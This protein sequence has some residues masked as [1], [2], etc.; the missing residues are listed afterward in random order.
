MV[1]SS[2]GNRQK[3]LRRRLKVRMQQWRRAPTSSRLQFLANLTDKSTMREF[4]SS[5]NIPLPQQYF[6]TSFVDEIDFASLP[7]R[8][9]VK[10]ANAS[11]SRAVMLFA[12]GVELFSNDRVPREAVANYVSSNI[13]QV[14]VDERRKILVEELVEDCDPTCLIPRDFKIYTAG[15][16]VHVIQVID[17]NGGKPYTQS[18]Y[19]R[20]WERLPELQRTYVP[21]VTYPAPSH[22]SRLLS[23]AEQI[24]QELEVFYRLDSTSRPAVR[25]SVSSLPTRSGAESFHQRDKNYACGSWHSTQT[26][27]P[28]EQWAENFSSVEV[29]CLFGEP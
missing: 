12:D 1:V 22:L 16:R 21:G 18:F 3:K 14:A 20:E 15:G 2:V 25:S 28:W 6:E 8:F 23:Y 4:I 9:V 26:H 11:S 17:R 7:D 10:P 29:R 27:S 5:R 24:S 13:K 19:S